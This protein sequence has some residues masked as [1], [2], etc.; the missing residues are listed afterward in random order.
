M[1]QPGLALTLITSVESGTDTSPAGGGL[2]YRD[3]LGQT[4]SGKV[5]CKHR[6]KNGSDYQVHLFH[7]REFFPLCS[8]RLRVHRR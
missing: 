4:L 2:G 8:Q 3:L 5:L 6:P 1:V 7:R